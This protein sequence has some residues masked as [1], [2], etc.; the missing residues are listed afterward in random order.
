MPFKLPEGWTTATLVGEQTL[1]TS[2]HKYMVTV[3][4]DKRGFRSGMST[5]GQLLNKTGYRGRGWKQQLV[6]DAV[7][8]LVEATK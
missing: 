5:H 3:D 4:F 6:D 7:K 2:P 8:W 1:L